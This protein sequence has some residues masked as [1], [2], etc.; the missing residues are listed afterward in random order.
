MPARKATGVSVLTGPRSRSASRPQA[1]RPGMPTALRVRSRVS[2][3]EGERER[4]ELPKV[5]IYKTCYHAGGLGMGLLV[6]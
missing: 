3:V 6:L 2:E 5:L 4:M 1:R